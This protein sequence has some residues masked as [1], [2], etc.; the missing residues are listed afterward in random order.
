VPEYPA[1]SAPSR[2]EFAAQRAGHDR[3]L[4][5]MH[6]LEGTLGSAAPGRE[7]EWRR[8]VG[9][10]LEALSKAVQAEVA[11]AAAPDSLLSDLERNHPRLRSR[12][13]GVRAQYASIRKTLEEL[14]AE[15]TATDALPDALRDVLR[16]VTDV[17]DLRQRCSWLLS[18]LRHLRARETDLLYEAYRDAFGVDIERE[19]SAAP[20]ERRARD[21]SAHFSTQR[22]DR[23]RSLG[24][25]Q[26]FER[27]AGAA[28]PGREHAWLEDMRASAF[29]LEV[30]LTVERSDDDEL[31][32][33]LERAE[34]RLRHR[35]DA[36]RRRYRDLAE[37]V[38]DIRVTLEEC[39]PEELDV[40]DLRRTLD[41]LATELRYLRARE[42]D[43]V[44]DAF[45]VDLGAGD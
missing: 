32:N 17:A 31:V 2:E 19:S 43:L 37:A 5:A 3:T 36:L 30:A 33:D 40:A 21:E 22:G 9:E 6:D 45:T 15:V 10:A 41:Q 39:E 12:V 42:A 13:H 34:P 11:D 38:H 1:D 27:L 24:A 23:A 25:L 7:E 35:I 26:H 16:D 14:R 44:Y 20:A 8:G 4:A 29:E 28:G 18:S